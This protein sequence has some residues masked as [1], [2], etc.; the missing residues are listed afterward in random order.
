MNKKIFLLGLVLLLAGQFVAAQDG[1]PSSW[2]LITLT[3]DGSVTNYALSDVQNIIFENNTMTIN[4]KSGDGATGISCISFA[5]SNGIK[6]LQAESSVFVFPNPVQTNL[7]VTGVP[8]DVKINLLNLSGTLLQSIP[9]QD[10]STN[11]NVSSLPA[12]L[13]LLQIGDQ[14]VKFIKQ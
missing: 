12:G 14:V 5:Q 10:N 4:M 7:T 1:S 8:K 9:A 2:Q 3:A 6:M 13:Y 11:I